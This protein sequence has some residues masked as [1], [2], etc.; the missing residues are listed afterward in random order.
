[1]KTD[2]DKKD[3]EQSK[4]FTIAEA[5]AHGITLRARADKYRKIA[6]ECDPLIAKERAA[7]WLQCAN[8]DELL[9][10]MMMARAKLDAAA[11]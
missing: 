10:D 2:T 1:M 8:T 4:P 11:E 7:L 9:A 6:Q 5:Q 3:S